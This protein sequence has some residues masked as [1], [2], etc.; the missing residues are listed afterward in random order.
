MADKG[1]RLPM[2]PLASSDTE[3]MIGYEDSNY[4]H[5]V[6]SFFKISTEY[7]YLKDGELVKLKNRN[8]LLNMYKSGK[9]EL[10]AR[11]ASGG[12]RG[13]GIPDDTW[14]PSVMRLAE[15]SEGTSGQLEA[16]ARIWNP[17]SGSSI[18]K[19]TPSV[20]APVLKSEG[21]NDLPEGYFLESTSQSADDA[22]EVSVE[23]L[24]QNKIY[25]IGDPSKGQRSR[26]KVSGTVRD[27]ATGKPM[28]DV[29]VW[30]DVTSSYTRTDSRG[31]Y[32]LTLPCGSNVINFSEMTRQE[33]NLKVEISGNGGLD[34]S[35][36]EKVTQLNSAIISAE[37]R[38]NHMMA[39]MGLERVS[40]KTISRI[41]SAFGE[42]DILK[43]VMALPGVKTVGEA[44]G[45]FN[46]RGGA[47][48]QN[49]IL[50]NEGTIY[51]PSHMFGIFS[52][53]NPDVVDGV[54]LYKSS[55]PVE[56]GG[57]ISSVLNVRGKEGDTKKVKGSLG[58]GLITSRF[59]MEGPLGKGKTTFVIGGRTTYS[60]WILGQLPKSNNYADG[61]AEFSDGN[62][63]ITHRVDSLNTIQLVGYYSRD[64]FSFN[65]DTTFRYNNLNAA[66]R[67]RHK[68]SG[69]T[70]FV[71]SAGYDRYSNELENFETLTEAYRLNTDIHQVFGRLK[72]ETLAG[73]HT[74]SY[75]AEVVGFGLQ[76]GHMTPFDENSFVLDR[77]LRTEYAIQ[78]S[79]YLGDT[80]RIDEKISLE[81]GG[82]LSSFLAMDPAK[83]YFGPEVRM[84]A[85]YSFTPNLSVKAG[86]NT[87][88]QYIH[89]ISNTSSISPMDT[90]KLC[91]ADI[92]PVT[93]W[94]GAGGIYWTVFDGKLDLSTEAYW[95][96]TWNYLDYKSGA[97]LVMNENLADD[98]VRT[99]GK[100]YGVEFMA[101]K[102]VGKLNGWLSYTYSRTFLKE[103]EDRGSNTINGGD[104]YKT[105]FDKPHDFKMVANYALTARFSLS[106][107]VDYST[108]RPVTVPV[109]W[110]K[111]GG[112]YRLAYSE[113]NG[114]R[115]PDYFRLDLALNIDPGHYLKKLTHMSVTLGC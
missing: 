3:G 16:A 113:R 15:S 94:Q 18:H 14:Y 37:S 42:G 90:W 39:K 55:I 63:G 80:W 5:D 23:A 65:Q 114:Y 107:N 28:P 13:R 21:G 97:L 19:E 77:Q 111:Y 106:A 103:M 108:G 74:L 12:L 68:G 115:V 22:S 2:W 104:W 52:A 6:L 110:F 70:S 7:L 62:L 76:G 89:L 1:G 17:S 31:R 47:S 71:A 57:R 50:F 30:D 95:K 78:P 105:A 41:P 82:R 79:A 102:S 98:L 73:N 69:S 60:D 112:G 48:D 92:R 88:R 26:A 87:L 51:N 56:Y 84:S 38:M 43:A 86:A 9:R 54:E 35:M 83:F 40:M 49:L 85:K 11:M 4:Q 67:W 53:F 24:Y 99:K 34:V 8:A 29:T 33:L 25:K 45:G 64:R 93:G 36:S 75:G 66:L 91:D 96:N 10:K 20:Y 44:S 59:H 61:K 46:V 100:A 81:Y 101:R 109:G 72:F 27:A 58:L 32:S